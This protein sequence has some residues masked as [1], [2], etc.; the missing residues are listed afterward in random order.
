[1]EIAT[2]SGLSVQMLM[3]VKQSYGHDTSNAHA[4]PGDSNNVFATPMIRGWSE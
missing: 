4:M 1:V 3:M 2:K